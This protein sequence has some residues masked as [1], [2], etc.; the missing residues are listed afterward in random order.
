IPPSALLLGWLFLG[1]SLGLLEAGGLLLI[2]LGLAAIDGRLHR[3]LV[4]AQRR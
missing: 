1:E 4:A 2:L 3:G